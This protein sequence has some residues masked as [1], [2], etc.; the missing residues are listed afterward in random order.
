MVQSRAARGLSHENRVAVVTGAAAGIGQE[1]AI[2]LAEQGA[3]LVLI[4]RDSCGETLGLLGDASVH[5]EQLDVGDSTAWEGVGDRVSARFGRVD[6][7]VN[8]AGIYPHATLD[9]LTYELW[10]RV[11]RV[12]LDSQFLA[13]KTFVPFMKKNGWGAIINI[14]SNSIAT[15]LPGSSHYMAS[16]M[17]IIGFTRG[18]SNELGEFGIT[19]NAVGPALTRTPGTSGTPPEFMERIAAGQAIK[20]VAVPYDIVGPILFL[21]S[22]EGRFVTG[23]TL[24]VDGGMMKN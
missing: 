16:K 22:E 12:N 13:A 3:A 5:V 18:L 2:R 23:Q 19:V 9:E 7:L 17:G 1:A 21:S 15:N 11:L 24:I 8:N 14:T 10:S 20:R 4:D 6:I